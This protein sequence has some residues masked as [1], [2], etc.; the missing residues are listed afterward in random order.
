MDFKYYCPE[1]GAVMEFED[2]MEDILCCPECG[3][4]MDVDMYG[5]TEEEYADMQADEAARNLENM[6]KYDPVMAEL[7]DDLMYEDPCE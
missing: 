4:S 2:D 7:M 1:C 3:Y 6:R 5:Y